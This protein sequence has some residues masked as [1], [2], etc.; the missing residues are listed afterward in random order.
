MPYNHPTRTPAYTQA[1]LAF[2]ASEYPIDPAKI[3]PAKRGYYGE[4]WRVDSTEGQ[5]CFVKLDYDAEHQQ[6]YARSLAAAEHLYGQGIDFIPRVIKT[7]AGALYAMFDGAVMGV[8][9][10]FEGANNETDESKR[11]EYDL[12]GRIYTVPAKGIDLPHMDF[13]TESADGF[14][15]RWKQ[16]KNPEILTVLEE[17][18]PALEHYA[19]RL[20]HFAERCKGDESR[21]VITHGDAGGNML[22]DGE[23]YALPDWDEACIA[24]PERD[25][26]VMCSRP[27][28][29]ELFNQTL[30]A[31]GINYV[32]RPERLAYFC[33]H[34]YF[35]YLNA[36]LDGCTPGR[37]IGEYL[38][39]ITDRMRLADEI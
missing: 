23:S 13:S 27:W 22:V 33:C 11:L 16:Q 31:H 6:I 37:E 25:A 2:L 10:W 7:R 35:F 26:W 14:F 4:T 36:H 34:M 19:E 12:L 15:I 17:H 1:L 3:T 32:L 28:A 5:S 9:D 29:V 30:A 21:Y 39:W 24:P 20:A 8:F 38:G 18:R